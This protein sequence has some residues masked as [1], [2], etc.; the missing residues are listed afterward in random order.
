MTQQ[1]IRN[2]RISYDTDEGPVRIDFHG[3]VTDVE[4]THTPPEPEWVLGRLVE[5]PDDRPHQFEVSIMAGKGE[6][7]FLLTQ[8]K[9]EA[10]T[11]A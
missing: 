3:P 7:G 4:V 2:L 6:N 11:Q 10:A 8:F 5:P 9:G 1:Q